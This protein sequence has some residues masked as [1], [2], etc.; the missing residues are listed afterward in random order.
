MARRWGSA[1]VVASIVAFGV[2]G[3]VYLWKESQTETA[4]SGD[5]VSDASA[6]AR[7][8][9]KKKSGKKGNR[10]GKPGGKSRGGGGGKPRSSGGGGG[11]NVAGGG[12]GGGGPVFDPV[13]GNDPGG[14]GTDD[15]DTDDDPAPAPFHPPFT[16]RGPAGP[17]YESAIASNKQEVTIGSQSGPDLTNAQLS[18]PMR[19]GAFVGECG[20]PDAMKVTVKVAI[21]NGRP[22]GVS[23]Y[24]PDPDIA[25]CI[26]RYVRTFSWPSNP[27]MDSFTTTY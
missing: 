1:I 22:V 11:G 26:D 8:S 17:T 19:N 6:D 21:K 25:G 9:S 20:A 13:P 16:G 10:G 12:G 24:A 4:Q 15:D 27:K 23:V 18:G 7:A 5:V 14:S 2:G 3:G